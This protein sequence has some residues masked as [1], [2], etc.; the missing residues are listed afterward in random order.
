MDR[1]KFATDDQGSD[2]YVL[3]YNP[4]EIHVPRAEHEGKT[5]SVESLDGEAVTFVKYFDTRRGRMF[6]KGWLTDHIAFAAQLS[7]L[8]TYEGDYMYMDMGSIGDALSEYVTWT[9]VKIVAINRVLR[10]GGALQYDHVELV[11]E[12]AEV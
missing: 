1:I 4:C 10:E 5:N 11:W 2:E 12:D 6:W 3:T 9:K 8:A 7:E